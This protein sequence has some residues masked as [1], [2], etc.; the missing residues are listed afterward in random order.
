MKENID[1]KNNKNSFDEYYIEKLLFS[2]EKPSI[3]DDLKSQTLNKIS[4]LKQIE[5]ENEKSQIKIYNYIFGIFG[6]LM[7]LFGIVVAQNLNFFS[8]LL[9]MGNKL[10][11]T[12]NFNSLL[13]N[14]KYIILFLSIIPG[15][16]I[17]YLIMKK[18][19]NNWI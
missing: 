4:K 14:L 6:I 5:T 18:K 16:I 11:K 13:I 1:D 10:L 19:H 7:L 15:S 9:L 2:R 17:F 12:I 3:S 8:T